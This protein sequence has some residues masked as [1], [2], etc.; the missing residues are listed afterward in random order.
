MLTD[1]GKQS[2]VLSSKSGCSLTEKGKALLEK[3]LRSYS[4]VDIKPF[5][6]SILTTSP[7]SIG[8]HIQNK[9]DKIDSAMKLRDLGVRGGAVG[10]T[11]ILYKDDK[12]TIPSINEDFFSK[13]PTLANKINEAFS[14][15]NNDILAVISAKDEWRGIEASI[16]IAK[17]LK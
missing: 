6:D 8:L 9:A 3:R 12:L 2:Y 16:T 4:I 17:A 7:I 14:L 11:I 10:T 13:Q 15:E 5:Y 1:L